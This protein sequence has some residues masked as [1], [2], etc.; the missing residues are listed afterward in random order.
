MKKLISIFITY[1]FLFG[2]LAK[3]QDCKVRLPQLQG[4]Y[5]G[6]CSKGL[7]H[8]NGF[9]VGTEAFK[10][11]FKKGYPSGKGVYTYANSEVYHGA[12]RKG[13]KSGFGKMTIKNDSVDEVKIGIWRNDEFRKKQL[14]EVMYMVTEKRNLNSVQMRH[15]NYNLDKITIIYKHKSGGNS[16]PTE[17]K[18]SASSGIMTDDRNKVVF[19]GVLYPFSIKIDFKAQ[20]PLNTS[21]YTVRTSFEI[22]EPGTWIVSLNY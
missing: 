21:I 2:L 19:E 20:N 3:A 12:F 4:V 22:Y 18:L 13:M 15:M 17:P 10:G 14:N 9:A 1:L 5:T 16:L 7:A 6:E 11:Q 8:G